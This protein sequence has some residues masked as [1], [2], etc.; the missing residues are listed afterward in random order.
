VESRSTAIG[1]R[2]A[3][4]IPLVPLAAE[5]A[6]GVAVLSLDGQVVRPRLTARAC[7]PA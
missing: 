1:P 3:E 4:A 2:L 7:P 5:H 6:I